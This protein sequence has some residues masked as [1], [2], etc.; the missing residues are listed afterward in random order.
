M[1][2]SAFNFV[3]NPG[4]AVLAFDE[5]LSE[6]KWEE[7]EALGGTLKQK[8]SAMARPVFIVDLSKLTFMGSSIV[9]L[10]VKLW[11]ASQERDGGMVVVNQHAVVK[12]VLDV[13]GLTKVWT[14]VR[15]RDEAT[16]IISRPPFALPS[17]MP[18]FFLAI[19]GWIA[20][21]GSVGFV[22]AKTKQL[23]ALTPETAQ[24]LAF[25]CAGFAG[26]IGIVSALRN[27]PK[28]WKALGLSLVCVAGCLVAAA[29]MVRPA[30]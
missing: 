25:G 12:D 26:L 20:A 11:K 16:A 2:T 10:I 8:I 17:N 30:V 15:T 21:A 29:I 18:T 24:L 5:S 9:A 28:L 22:L 3:E 13:S 6:A 19:L 14:I 7:I 27:V 4:H 1:T 23:T